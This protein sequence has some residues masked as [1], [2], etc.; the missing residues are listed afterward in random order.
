MC[1]S[2]SPSALLAP[3]PLAKNHFAD[4][5]FLL[6]NGDVITQ[7]DLNAFLKAGARNGCDLTVGY[8]KYIYR[9]PFGVLSIANGLVEGITEKPSHKYSL[10]RGIYCVRSSALDCI[11][12]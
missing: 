10:S 3:L 2:R 11:P 1:M 7:L 9:S 5:M 12:P 4:E 8:K 6:M